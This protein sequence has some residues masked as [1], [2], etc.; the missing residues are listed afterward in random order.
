MPFEQR[1]APLRAPAS[2]PLVALR[3]HAPARPLDR[4]WS[5]LRRVPPDARPWAA[6]LVLLACAMAAVVGFSLTRSH[7]SHSA[8]S[9][10]ESDPLA[11]LP[12]AGTAG[13]P[14]VT[15]V[16]ELIVHAAGAVERPGLYRLPT[17]A[18]VGD[19]LDAAGGA[20]ADADR[21]RVNLAAPMNDGDRVYVPRVGEADL[22]IVPDLAEPEIG[23]PSVSSESGLID[24]N[25]A[26]AEQL[27]ELPGVGP[28]IAR[29]IVDHREAN[30][31]FHTVDELLEVRGIGPSRLEQIRALVRV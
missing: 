30:G 6:A 24:V 14:A 13:A 21:D 4:L 25:R 16:D 22:P 27:E 10:P 18:R 26:T 8:S 15:E 17:D 31:P 2:D 3:E 19:L 28:S 11:T 12:Y 5:L 29:A 1:D 9:L 23:A 20:T 7:P